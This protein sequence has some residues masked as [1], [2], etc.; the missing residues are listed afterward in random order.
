MLEIENEV[1]HFEKVLRDDGTNW[2]CETGHAPFPEAREMK[3]EDQIRFR[4]AR[5]AILEVQRVQ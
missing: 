5:T 2:L 4:Q 3:K 1:K